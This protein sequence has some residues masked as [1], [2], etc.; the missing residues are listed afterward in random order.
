M[1]S[2]VSRE[3]WGEMVQS[4]FEKSPDVPAQGGNY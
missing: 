4:L 3:A 2:T 1:D